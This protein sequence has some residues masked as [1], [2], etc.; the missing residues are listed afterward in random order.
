MTGKD[1]RAPAKTISNIMPYHQHHLSRGCLLL[2]CVGA[3]LDLLPANAPA[4]GERLLRLLNRSRFA[5]SPSMM[6]CRQ[7][8]GWTTKYSYPAI[9]T[10]KESRAHLETI[11]NTLPSAFRRMERAASVRRLNFERRS[12]RTE[13]HTS[14]S[15][16]TLSSLSHLSA[17][18]CERATRAH[19]SATCLLCRDEPTRVRIDF[20]EDILQLLTCSLDAFPC[21]AAHVPPLEPTYK[22]RRA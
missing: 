20:E 7:Q 8:C 10:G 6:L 9:V 3:C 4:S 5:Q 12:P 21:G 22:T 11:L 17:V 1:P 14:Q 15:H 19:R 18:A 2:P 16:P 13:S